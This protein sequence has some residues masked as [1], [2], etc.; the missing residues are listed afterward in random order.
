MQS[1]WAQDNDTTLIISEV[2]IEPNDLQQTWIE[3]YNP[4]DKP[5]T[6]SKLRISQVRT[7]NVLP[8]SIMRGGGIVIKPGT[9]IVL[10]AN[11]PKFYSRWGTHVIP[12]NLNILAI[13]QTGGFLAI[14]TKD[15]NESGIDAFGFGDQKQLSPIK[16]LSNNKILYFSGN[17]RSRARK[18][19][20]IKDGITFTD[21]LAAI[22]TP[23]MPNELE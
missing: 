6:L 18:I 16:E 21:Y 7:P 1:L 22:P 17:N 3:I 11:K 8:D 14:S 20:R 19:I 23:G 2:Y 10:C 12:I 5:L 13:F 4:S 15:F 9:Y